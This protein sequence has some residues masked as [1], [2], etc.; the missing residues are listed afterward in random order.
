MKEKEKDTS[1]RDELNSWEAETSNL[2]SPIKEKEG[3]I[4]NDNFVIRTNIHLEW[5]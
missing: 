3:K 4:I 5:E 2:G 1:V